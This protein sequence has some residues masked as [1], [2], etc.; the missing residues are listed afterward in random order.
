MVKLS[1]LAKVIVVQI[2]QRKPAEML[3]TFVVTQ[4]FEKKRK[5][6]R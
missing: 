5:K 6:K 2:G 4:K 1:T 3:L